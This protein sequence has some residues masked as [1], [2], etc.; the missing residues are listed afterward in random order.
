VDRLLE[1]IRVRGYK[2]TPKR[3]EMIRILY[4]KG[5]H[6]TPEE[7]CALLKRRFKKI[8]LP[9]VY[10]NLETLAECGVLVR[11]HQLDRQRHYA[12]CSHQG[13]KHHHHIVC[14]GCNKVEEMSE[15]KVEAPKKVHGFRVLEHFL[16]FQGICPDCEIKK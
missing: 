3:I 12:V 1:K 5:G 8:G 14:T 6:F 15:C 16:Q 4:A 9:S 7:V 13:D 10:R 11:I 2:L